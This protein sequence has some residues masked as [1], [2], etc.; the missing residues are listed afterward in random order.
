[1]HLKHLYFNTYMLILMQRISYRWNC[2]NVVRK[3]FPCIKLSRF[4]KVKHSTLDNARLWKNFPLV[5]LSIIMS[6]LPETAHCLPNFHCLD[7]KN[8]AR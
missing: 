7:L 2:W 5:S 6:R 3:A 1:M 4:E 8:T